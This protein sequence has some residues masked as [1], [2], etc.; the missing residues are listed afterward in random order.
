MMRWINA[1][2]RADAYI[3]AFGAPTGLKLF[4][5][6]RLPGGNRELVI[7][8]HQAPLVIRRNT[9]DREV[10]EYIYVDQYYER[11]NYPEHPRTIVDAG[12]YTGYSSIY[13]STKFADARILAIEPDAGNFRMLVRN[14][15]SCARIDPTHAALWSTDASISIAN[16]DDAAWG[17]RAVQ[18]EAGSVQI[19]TIRMDEALAWADGHIDLLKLNIEGAERELFAA[20]DLSW[21]HHVDT[22]M[23][24]VHDWIAP[25]SS[26]ALYRAL[27]T[28]QFQQQTIDSSPLLIQRKNLTG[29]PVCDTGNPR[30]RT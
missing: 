13:F 6:L 3:Q 12:A 2:R 30:S 4:T 8:G 24:E 5:L 23:I 1:I 25:G 10:F 9:T 27:A 19:P 17:Y 21:L 28:S 22:I 15:R 16:P 26:M 11:W 7:P 29:T 18:Q 20:P 14:T